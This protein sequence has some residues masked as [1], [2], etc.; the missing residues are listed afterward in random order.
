MQAQVRVANPTNTYR[1]GI[2]APSTATGT[3]VVFWAGAGPNASTNNNFVV[4][5]DGTAQITGEIRATAGYIGSK[6]GTTG[7]EFDSTT[8]KSVDS[9]LMFTANG[10]SGIITSTGEVPVGGG[11][12]DVGYLETLDDGSQDTVVT[13]TGAPINTAPRTLTITPGYIKSDSFL[14]LWSTNAFEVFQ[15][16]GTN[17]LLSFDATKSL[18]STRSLIVGKAVQSL[19]N[20]VLV[21]DRYVSNKTLLSGL[22]VNGFARVRNAT[23]TGPGTTGYFRN[24]YIGTSASP[25]AN[26]GFE[27]A[28]Y[29]QY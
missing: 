13:T 18:I 12:I 16:Q 6:D 23:P 25:S 4:Q 29:I 15:T 20:G 17:P 27:G 1:A 3:D 8:I 7:W 9:S 5:A 28:V 22:H 11:L 21:D 10:T 24:I 14:T 2:N 19:Q 26:T